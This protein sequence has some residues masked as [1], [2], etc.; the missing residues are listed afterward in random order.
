MVDGS[1]LGLQHG[2]GSE[3]KSSHAGRCLGIC[4]KASAACQEHCTAVCSSNCVLVSDLKEK[5][6]ECSQ[7]V[8]AQRFLVSETAVLCVPQAGKRWHL[9]HFLW[10]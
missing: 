4:H 1:T 10:V 5:G 9:C 3:T 6:V 2:G 8:L 7:G